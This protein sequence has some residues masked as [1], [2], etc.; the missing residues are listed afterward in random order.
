M[1]KWH[2]LL[3]ELALVA[4]SWLTELINNPDKRVEQPKKKL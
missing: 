2:Q 3:L 1:K 4:L